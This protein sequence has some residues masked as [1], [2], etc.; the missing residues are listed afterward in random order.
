MFS[1]VV[2]LEV[3]GSPHKPGDLI[4]MDGERWFVVSVDYNGSWSKIY[5]EPLSSYIAKV[6]L[7][8]DVPYDCTIAEYLNR[9]CD[10]YADKCCC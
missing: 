6:T 9:L 4:H 10:D 5:V 8:S 1:K 2:T 7:I 3:A